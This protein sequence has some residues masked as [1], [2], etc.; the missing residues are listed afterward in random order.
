V[1]NDLV[2]RMPWEP[3]PAEETLALVQADLRYMTNHTAVL[4]HSNRPELQILVNV[5]RGEIVPRNE[6]KFKD[7]TTLEF[8]DIGMPQPKAPLMTVKELLAMVW[9]IVQTLGL[10]MV[11]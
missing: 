2:K 3:I 5:R 11:S 7:G 8:Q 4:V 6:V 10:E 9:D 1:A